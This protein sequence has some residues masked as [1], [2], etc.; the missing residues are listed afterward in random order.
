M[1]R[2]RKRCVQCPWKAGLLGEA[3]VSLYV[4][5][6][7]PGGSVNHGLQRGREPPGRTAGRSGRGPGNRGSAASLE[8]HSRPHPHTARRGWWQGRA[9]GV[10][11]PGGAEGR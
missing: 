9:R 2:E 6:G 8:R 4:P 10:R 7:V 11:A 5:V 1:E 3:S